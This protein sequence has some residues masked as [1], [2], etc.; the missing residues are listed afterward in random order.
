[1]RIAGLD[2]LNP[3]LLA[4]MC[5]VTNLPFRALCR[6][7]GA[8]LV[9]TE[10]I[11]SVELASAR[12]RSLHLMQ[13]EA[14]EQPVGVQISA[15]P[16]V[17]DMERAAALVEEHGASL[18]NLNCGCPVKKIVTGGSGSA[19]LKDLDLLRQICRRLRRVVSI[20]LTVKVRAGWDARTVNAL[21]VGRLCEDE[22]ID[23]LMIHARTREQGYDGTAN[24]RLIAELKAALSIPV[25]GNGDVFTP[26]DGRRMMAETGC[27][28]V[29]VGRGAMG[30]P[31]LF[32]GLVR[33]ADG[34]T[35]DSWRP[36]P[37]E[38]EQTFLRHLDRYIDWAGEHRAC[39][40]MR[41]QLLW[42]TLKLPGARALRRHLGTLTSRDAYVQ[43]TEAFFAELKA[44]TPS[45]VPV[46]QRDRAELK[47]SC[48]GRRKAA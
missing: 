23:A 46:A 44:T 41:K 24:W 10:M 2:C 33:W 6:E 28:G 39:L 13:F 43:A 12:V 36:S 16:Q 37:A 47:P 7:L 15:C 48:G 14:S 11:S 1:M 21:D 9:M 26:A 31:W 20:P 18:L 30:N 35:D 5:E 4:P 8:G 27:D 22:G 3:W 34:H 29:M 38:L 32:R 17:A 40:E 19:L 45:A 25:I 42:Y